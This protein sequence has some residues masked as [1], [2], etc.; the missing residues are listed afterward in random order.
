MREPERGRENE[1][2]VEYGDDDDRFPDRRIL[3]KYVLVGHGGQ[4]VVVVAVRS[5]QRSFFRHGHGLVVVVLVVMSVAVVFVQ[6]RC[7]LDR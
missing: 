7:A 3:L 2:G 6:K 4:V 1:S 5:V